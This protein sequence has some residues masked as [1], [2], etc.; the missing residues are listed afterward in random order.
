MAVAIR[1]P[2]TAARRTVDVASLVG[3]VTMRAV[4][5]E[6]KRL[7]DAEK[8]R[9]RLE[10]A[11]EALRRVPD[12]GPLAPPQPGALPPDPT[13][14]A[15]TAKRAPDPSGPVDSRVAAPPNRRQPHPK[16]LNPI[17]SPPAASR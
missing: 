7:D 11:I 15:S 10:T 4:D 3:W 2:L 16:S 1:G 17:E 6:A 5:Q 9:Q 12:A 13:P 8:E 14:Q